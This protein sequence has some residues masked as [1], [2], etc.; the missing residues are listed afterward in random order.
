M[1]LAALALMACVLDTRPAQPRAVESGT[2]AH[3]RAALHTAALA[4]RRALVACIVYLD[5]VSFGGPEDASAN[6]ACTAFAATGEIEDDTDRGVKAP[7]TERQ[8]TRL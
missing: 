1:R 6:A 5:A 3:V 4:Q 2:P 7:P 8:E